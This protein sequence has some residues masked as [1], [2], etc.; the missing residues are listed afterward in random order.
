MVTTWH[1]QCRERKTPKM[2]R[3]GRAGEATESVKT[4]PRSPFL[5]F[6]FVWGCHTESPANSL[7]EVSQVSL[8]LTAEGRGPPGDRYQFRGWCPVKVQR[9]APVRPPR[10]R[11]PRLYTYVDPPPI[12][13][14][15]CSCVTI[16]R[17]CPQA[18]RSHQRHGEHTGQSEDS[19][20]YENRASNQKK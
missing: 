5:V 4:R 18:R 15:W 12:S 16:E 6:T 17:R 1:F 20:D 11:I 19:N 10:G 7:R 8:Q 13:D 2:V 9:A 14:P 3:Q